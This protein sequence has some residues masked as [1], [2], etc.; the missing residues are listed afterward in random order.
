VHTAGF[1]DTD[2]Q[3]HLT[4][5]GQHD[6]WKQALAAADKMRDKFGESAVSLAAGMRGLYRERAHENPVGLPGRHKPKK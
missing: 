1:G 3:M 4:D 6:R 5:D 2:E